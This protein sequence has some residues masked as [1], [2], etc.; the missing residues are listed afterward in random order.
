MRGPPDL[1]WDGVFQKAAELGDLGVFFPKYRCLHPSVAA[2]LH[3][4]AAGERDP[5][6]VGDDP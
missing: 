1:A 5:S 4:R 3:F 6:F 2:I